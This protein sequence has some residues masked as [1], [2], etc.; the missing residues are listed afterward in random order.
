MNLVRNPAIVEGVLMCV[1]IVITIGVQFMMS[2]S[3]DPLTY[4]LPVDAE[5]FPQLEIPV[6]RTFAWA[7]SA[8]RLVSPFGTP[9]STGIASNINDAVIEPDNNAM[10]NTYMHP[11]IRDPK[12]IVWIAQ[13]NFGYCGR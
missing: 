1:L 2:S 6:S 9:V 11:T 4:Y 5:E 13:D 7:K 10:E 12:P 8:I 3:F